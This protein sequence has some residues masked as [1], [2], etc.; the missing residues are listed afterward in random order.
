M[1][2]RF[3]AINSLMLFVA[4]WS[5]CACPSS[6]RIPGTPHLPCDCESTV[7]KGEAPDLAE[8]HCADCELL[9]LPSPAET[10]QLL[11]AS[12]CQCSAVTNA[13]LAN[14]VELERHWAKVVI[15]CDSKRVQENL[16]LDRDLLALHAYGIR[17]EAAAAAMT[18]FYQLAGLESQKLY[19]AQG[20]E[21]TETTLDRIDRFETKGIELPKG[22]DRN[23]VVAR[24][25]ELTDK[26]LQ[27]DF[28]RIQL[29]GQLQKFIGC[30]LNEHRYYWPNIDWTP[31]LTPLD[32]ELELADGLSTRADLRGL[33][34]VLCNFE[35]T[36]L[37]VARGVLKFADSTIGSVE[38]VDGLIHTI[39]CF[40]CNHTEISV[41]CR[42][43][44]L[45]YKETERLATAE[46]KS[47]AYELTLQ[48]S[49]VTLAQE[50]V[51]ELREGLRKLTEKRDV[52][53][54]SAFAISNLRGQLFEAESNLVE[55]VVALKVAKV[56]LQKAQNT[57]PQQ[58]G[59][60]PK[61]CCEGQCCGA[62]MRCETSTCSKR[63]CNKCK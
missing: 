49:R 19:L 39:R 18:A 2:L 5:G 61:L 37:P 31:E 17:N 28:L 41:R 4:T 13:S 30:P 58:C 10:Y 9:P 36:T 26:H 34:I 33:S 55:Q 22:V 56:N 8:L 32:V 15:E 54:I 16:C 1:F 46:I 42:Q 45:F 50:T 60:M 29:N 59:F 52:D 53:D 48:Q 57:L 51:L 25:S 24:L 44:A 7:G 40:H 62:C 11:D 27:L 3:F 12:T 6:C 23:T 38:P 20:I 21:E 63:G 43:L 35:K 47:A 14:M